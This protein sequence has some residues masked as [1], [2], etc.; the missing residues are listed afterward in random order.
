MTL[1]L[2]RLL[3]I[4]LIAVLA[5]PLSAQSPQQTDQAILD[6][7]RQIR[8]LLE[9]LTTPSTA[10]APRQANEHVTLSL[11]TGR[12]LGSPDAPLTIVEF[13]DLQCPFCRQFHATTFEQLRADYIDTKKVR[14][15]SRDFP[16]V[17]LHPLSAAAARA[18]RCAGDQG[19]FWEMRHA[20]LSAEALTRESFFRQA[21][22]LK[23]DA[24]TFSGC[25][26]DTDRFQGEIGD[27]MRDGA[28]AGVTGTPSFV[29]GRTTGDTLDGVLVL[30]AQPYE[31]F[32]AQLKALLR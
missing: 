5:V 19:K 14:Y 27:D 21:D 4:A 25:F 22:V 3:A 10:P 1:T 29:L 2:R 32:D 24:P 30:G 18:S 15:F 28:R 12:M 11:K 7:L 13:T 9:R 6:E 23:L 8:Q 31:A 16:I 17:E 26:A 20:I